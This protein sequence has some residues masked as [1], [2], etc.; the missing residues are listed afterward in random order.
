MEANTE[1]KARLTTD[2]QEIENAVKAWTEVRKNADKTIFHLNQG[3]SFAFTR[4]KYDM[5]S[6]QNPKS[7]HAYPTVFNGQLAFTLIDEHNDSQKVIDFSLVH[8]AHYTYGTPVPY[9]NPM[10]HSSQNDGHEL[11]TREALERVF[12]WSMNKNSWVND[13]VHTTDG[14]FQ[15][16]YIPFDDLKKL[17]KEGIKEVYVAIGL[18]TDGEPDLILWNEIYDFWIPSIAADVT[19]PGPPFT[20]LAPEETFQLLAQQG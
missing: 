1:T 6:K 2:G 20:A 16:F 5:W 4:D 17:F 18:K 13:T 7:L 8:V 3:N 15:A 9:S 11:T 14:I 19:M 12:R 10:P